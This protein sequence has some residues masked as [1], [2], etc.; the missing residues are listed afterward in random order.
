MVCGATGRVVCG[1]TGCVV[2]AA[3]VVLR[4]LSRGEVAGALGGCLL[5]VRVTLMLQLLMCLRFQPCSFPL[6][7]AVSH[8]GPSP[9]YAAHAK[10]ETNAGF[11]VE[12]GGCVTVDA[13][14]AGIIDSVR[15]KRW[16]M[17]YGTQAAATVLR[18]DQIIMAKAAG[19]PKSK[20]D[21]RA[22]AER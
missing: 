10:G 20:P 6:V 3:P 9:R 4:W 15:T 2:C 19:G 11:D 18:V 5:P 13:A 7:V 14:K 17:N 22:A 8:G 21:P 16:S 12:A 1:A